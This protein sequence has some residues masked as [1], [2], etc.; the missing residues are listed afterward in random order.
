MFGSFFCHPHFLIHHYQCNN[1][2]H[3]SVELFGYFDL[4]HYS[5]NLIQIQLNANNIDL[6]W[7]LIGTM[8]GDQ[9]HSS[10]EPA[11][12]NDEPLLPAYICQL[13]MSQFI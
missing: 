13:G 7:I 11:D 9:H 10:V 5:F 1:Q 8:Q 3:S 2:A 12:S 4:M 6:N